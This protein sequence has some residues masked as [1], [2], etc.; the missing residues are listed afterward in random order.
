MYKPLNYLI[1]F[2][3]PHSW[4]DSGAKEAADALADLDFELDH[5]D[6]DEDSMSEKELRGTCITN[7]YSIPHS[8]FF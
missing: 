7:E 4:Q 5:Q 8:S 3:S 2:S 1:I 6:E